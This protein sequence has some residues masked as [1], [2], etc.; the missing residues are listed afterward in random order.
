MTVLD[1]QVKQR[2]QFALNFNGWID[3]Q[4]YNK[5][6]LS[7]LIDFICH[8]Y[9]T[10]CSLLKIEHFSCLLLLRN[11]IGSR[12][13]TPADTTT[14]CQTG[15]YKSRN[16]GVERKKGDNIYS[17]A[18]LE[19]IRPIIIIRC[20]KYPYISWAHSFEFNMVALGLALRVRYLSLN[21]KVVVTARTSMQIYLFLYS[22]FL[23]I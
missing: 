4:V 7:V 9:D 2:A 1:Q 21:Y 6:E 12:A 15:N 3:I 17:Y 23:S 14:F 8:T 16:H 19:I 11:D 5:G 20:H 13:R 18:F 22:I 10:A